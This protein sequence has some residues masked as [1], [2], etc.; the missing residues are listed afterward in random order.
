MSCLSRAIRK[1]HLEKISATGVALILFVPSF[2]QLVESVSES[3][4]VVAAFL[5]SPL[6]HSAARQRSRH[7][8]RLHRVKPCFAFALSFRTRMLALYS[9]RVAV[10]VEQPLKTETPPALNTSTVP[11]EVYSVAFEFKVIS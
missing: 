2:L 8:N 6:I 11:S 9:S 3:G 4:A 7:L 1:P 10:A 5:L